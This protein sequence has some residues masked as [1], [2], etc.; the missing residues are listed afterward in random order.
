M[1]LV[2]MYMNN[3]QTAERTSFGVPG[4]YCHD[5]R[6]LGKNYK[7]IY[8][9]LSMFKTRMDWWQQKQTFSG[10][11]NGFC[12]LSILLSYNIY[13]RITVGL[14]R[15]KTQKKNTKVLVLNYPYYLNGLNGVSHLSTSIITCCVSYI[16]T[17]GSYQLC[18]Y[19]HT[20]YRYNYVNV[21]CTV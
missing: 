3:V 20:I 19:T 17:H 2:P 11:A 9:T 7:K 4:I 18:P 5:L 21:C 13:Y 16:H 6:L 1:I 10:P 12:S 14:T 15:S 8:T